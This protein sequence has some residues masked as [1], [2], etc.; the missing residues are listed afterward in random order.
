MLKDILNKYWK[1]GWISFFISASC[2]LYLLHFSWLKWGDLIIDLGRDMYVPLEILSGKLLYRDVYYLHGPFSPYFNAILFK[3]LGAHI[4]S[5]IASGIITTL[6]VS[7]LIYKISRLFLD[8]LSSTFVILTFLFVFAFGQYVYLGNYNFIIPYAYPAIHGMLFSL[9]SLYTFYD[10]LFKKAKYICSLPIFFTFL[11]RI[12]IG[13]MLILAILVTFII[14]SLFEGVGFRKIFK[15]LLIYLVIPFIFSATI[16]SLFLIRA[17]D[18]VQRGNLWDI[19]WTSNINSPFVRFHSGFYDIFENTKIMFR[20]FIYYLLL[21]II[22]SLGGFIMTYIYRLRSLFKKTLFFFLTG[23]LFILISFYFFRKFFNYNL[24]YRCLPIICLLTFFIALW[25]FI[26]TKERREKLRYLFLL[27]VSLFSLFLII[28]KLFF[29]WAGHYGFYMLLPGMVIYYVFFLKIVPEVL[30]PPMSRTFFRLSFLYIFLLFI[31]SHFT[32]SRFC[33]AQKTLKVSSPRGNLYVFNNAREKRNKEL[34]EF[35]IEN[36][37]KE[38]SLVVF[39]E[40]LTINFLSERKNPLY[41]YTYLPFDLVREEVAENIISEMENEKVDYIVLV[42]RDTAE[43]GYYIF[44]K[45]YGESIW[46]YILE[47]YLPYKQFGPFPFT[48]Q[49]YGIALFK[50]KT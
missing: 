8:I 33:Y 37:A 45:D 23:S 9:L 20:T 42:Q 41:Y 36:T 17:F 48:T 2:F 3:M 24:Q 6:V 32:I 5:L 25:K 34:I 10:S 21:C 27:T 12:E 38:A 46:K 4:H 35:L 30:K 7:I 39:P 40:G 29:V 15:H 18:V 44:G 49:D 1:K 47:K 22:F 13:L 28:R 16:Y 31:M 43:F 26:K 50:R 14:H 11:C 19:I